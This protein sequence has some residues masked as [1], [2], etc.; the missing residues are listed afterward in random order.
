[1][2]AFTSAVF[3]LVV[4]IGGLGLGPTVIGA[5]S[6]L[7][8]NRFG[9]GEASLRYALPTVVAP[10]T[11]AALLFWRSSTHLRAELKPLHRSVE[12]GPAGV[13][14]GLSEAVSPAG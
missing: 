13:G 4:S 10:A 9:L 8:I 2:R 12:S 3:V 14:E 1:M 11:A 5:L 7:F 6:D